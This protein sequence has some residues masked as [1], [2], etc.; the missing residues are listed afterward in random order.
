MALSKKQAQAALTLS[1]GRD[2]V[3]ISGA[4]LG[5]AGDS[6]QASRLADDLA[7]HFPEDTI[8]QFSYLPTIRAA[9]ALWSGDPR[10][11]MD[12]LAT[13]VSYELGLN[14]PMSLYLVYLRGAAYLAAHQG[15]AAAAEFQRILDHPSVVFFEPIG[16]LAHLQIGRAYTLADDRNKAKTAYQDF[17]TLWK[18]ADPDIPILKQAKA[19]YA[20]LQ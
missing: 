18:D 2:V 1:N 11:A 17:F 10:K 3:A 4:A 19:E 15:H 9:T 5:L 7:N 6:R 16:A 14:P 12:A 8:V 13:S 20:K